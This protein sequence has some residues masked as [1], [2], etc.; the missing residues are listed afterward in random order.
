MVKSQ[1]KYID[2]Y[3]IKRTDKYLILGTIHPYGNSELDFFYGNAKTFWGILSNATKLN[4]N[5]LYNIL[6]IFNQNKI[7]ISDMILECE[8]EDETVTKDSDLYNL[9]LNK[10]IINK[11]IHSEI[12]TIFFTSAFGKNNAAKLFFDLF[13]LNIQVPKNWKE[14]YEFYIAIKNKKI[15]CII[16]LS[17]S[18][19]SNI[20]ISKSKIYQSKKDEYVKVYEK[21]VKQFKID[22]YQSKFEEAFSANKTLE[23][24]SLPFG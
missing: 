14:T 17:P 20:G 6:E 23:R 16:L 9:K 22:F 21:P 3:P 5:T 11:I 13:E 8:R 15:K 2:K 10:D 12:E 24:N 7:A 4:F 1:H 19:A 18:G